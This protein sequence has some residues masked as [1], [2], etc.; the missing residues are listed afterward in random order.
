MNLE[1]RTLNAEPDPARGEAR[2]PYRNGNEMKRLVICAALVA[3]IL[4]GCADVKTDVSASSPAGGFDGARTYQ[5]ARAP[6]PGGSALQAQYEAQV[7]GELA[8][9]GFARE[10][11]APEGAAPPADGARYL[12]SLAYDT[13]PE[14]VR[15][16]G[17][18]CESGCGASWSWPGTHPFVH[19]LT[20]RFFERASGREV[21]RVTVTQRDHDADPGHAS[22]YLVKSAFAQ[23]P[24]A[25]HPAWR[26]KLHPGEAGAAPAVVS[27]APLE[28]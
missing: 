14:A 17:D 28:R 16:V 18:S 13:R 25:E 11:A 4:S 6:Q 2:P 23:F 8:A 20:L 22:A 24:F 12:V 1:C 10:P 15:I 3:A 5:L 7:A 9:R 21:Y 19:T 27:V 26:V